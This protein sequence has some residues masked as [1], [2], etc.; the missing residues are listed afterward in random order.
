MKLWRSIGS[1]LPAATPV[2]G[3]AHGWSAPSQCPLSTGGFN[4]SSQHSS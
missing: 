3:L 4:G 2:G 1:D